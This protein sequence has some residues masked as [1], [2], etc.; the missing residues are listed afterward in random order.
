MPKA[1]VLHD[2]LV[3]GSVRHVDAVAL[4]V[5]ERCC[6]GCPNGI[7]LYAIVI[8]VGKDDAVVGDVRE[9]SVVYDLV[10]HHNVVIA[11]LLQKNAVCAVAHYG[12]ALDGVVV[13][14]VVQINPGGMVYVLDPAVHHLRVGHCLEENPNHDPSGL[15]RPVPIYPK[16]LDEH[17]V[18]A[19]PVYHVKGSVGSV[20]DE[21][22]RPGALP[23]QRHV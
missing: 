8:R 9:E 7:A 6:R 17:A 13:A 3:A 23:D 10:A 1:V 5:R 20:R 18:D 2:V 4:P 19:T 22:Y 12:V 16:V 21:E 11:T 14:P 15:V